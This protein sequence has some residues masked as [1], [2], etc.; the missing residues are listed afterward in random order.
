ML[1]SFKFGEADVRDYGIISAMKRS[2]S[3][4]VSVDQIV[5]KFLALRLS[6]LFTTFFLK[7]TASS[8]FFNRVKGALYR[9]IQRERSIFWRGE[10]IIHCEKR[11]SYEHVSDSEWLQR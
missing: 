2:A 6:Q 10:S 4:E 5:H 1:V 11:S 9:V 3:S 7:G 8:P